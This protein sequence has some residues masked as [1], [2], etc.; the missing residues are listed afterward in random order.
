VLRFVDSWSRRWRRPSLAA[1]DLAL[2]L[3]IAL[4]I[5]EFSRVNGMIFDEAALAL[6]VATRSFAELLGPLDHVQMAPLL[7]LW[8]AKL[9]VVVLGVSEW[10]LRLTPLLAGIGALVL[11]Q[12]CAA[13]ILSS[14]SAAFAMLLLAL[15]T[16]LVHYAAVF[17]QYSSDALA[18]T[19]LLSL[20]LSWYRAPS[21]RSWWALVVAGAFCLA[22]SMPSVFVLGGIGLATALLVFRAPNRRLVPEV[23]AGLALWLGTFG[24]VFLQ[25]SQDPDRTAF[26]QWWWK[27][28]FLDPRLPDFPQRVSTAVSEAL[29]AAFTAPQT[30]TLILILFTLGVIVGLLTLAYRGSIVLLSTLLVPPMLL[31]AASGLHF[32]PVAARFLL[33]FAPYV[34]LLVAIGIDGIDPKVR[35]PG[36]LV[37]GAVLGFAVLATV[38]PGA[39]RLATDPSTDETGLRP[40]VQALEARSRPG[41]TVYLYNKA[42]IVYTFY[43]TDWRHQPNLDR[44][45]RYAQLFDA[46][47][48]KRRVAP[49]DTGMNGA[50]LRLVDRGRSTVLGIG[51]G[52]HY[53]DYRGF[54]SP[55]LDPGWDLNEL[56][57]IRAEG[58]RTAWLLFSGE[59]ETPRDQ[60]LQR[61]REAGGFLDWHLD[62]RGAYLYRIRFP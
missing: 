58:S 12:R 7:F 54:L 5:R 41:E 34:V 45:R 40:L 51:T 15:S 3:G 8:G 32:Y 46:R 53:L 50:A 6:N 38:V 60:L 21:R 44:P 31:A 20:A 35:S 39:W 48:G 28:S 52:K 61:I 33:C 18:T 13:R 19:L 2:L 9:S 47:W 57:R 36:R 14:W 29:A 11:F 23:I 22:A 16:E 10:A 26:F 1:A 56:R 55:E 49:P 59:S 43:S 25:S 30:P 37:W 17:K 4:R 62:R 24:V 27:Y 42:I